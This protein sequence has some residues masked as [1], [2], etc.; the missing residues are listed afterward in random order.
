MKGQTRTDHFRKMAGA[1]DP[2]PGSATGKAWTARPSARP[3]EIC[4]DALEPNDALAH[5]SMYASLLVMWRF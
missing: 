1:N 5:A 4:F 3:S 2:F